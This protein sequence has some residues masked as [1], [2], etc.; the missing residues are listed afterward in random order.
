MVLCL[1]YLFHFRSAQKGTATEEVN[2]MEAVRMP[3]EKN[4]ESAGKTATAENEKIRK[5][6]KK[7][8]RERS[9]KVDFIKK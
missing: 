3:R 1:S 8:Y 7:M 6:Y 9:V 5:S 2:L 4:K